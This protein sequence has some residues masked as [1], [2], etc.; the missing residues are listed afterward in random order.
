MESIRSVGSLMHVDMRA[1]SC[2][3]LNDENRVAK[4]GG[5]FC[6]AFTLVRVGYTALFFGTKVSI[7]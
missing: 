1:C 5:L 2:S 7:D 3:I 6:I 4:C